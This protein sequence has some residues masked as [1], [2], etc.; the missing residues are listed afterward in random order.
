MFSFISNSTRVSD[1]EKFMKY[2]PMGWRKTTTTYSYPSYTIDEDS[3]TLI[4]PGYSQDELN[5]EIENNSLKISA[6][7]KSE[8]ETFY[9]R[10][11]ETSFKIKDLDK[12]KVE[13]SLVNGILTIDFESTKPEKITKKIEIK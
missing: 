11:F 10:S 4:V 3:I 5:I 6:E 13:A 12:D 9:K 1:L 2:E 7:I 8:D